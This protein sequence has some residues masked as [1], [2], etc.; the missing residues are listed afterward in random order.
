MLAQPVGVEDLPVETPWGSEEV[1]HGARQVT[2]EPSLDR[3]R[4]RP[5]I[6]SAVLDVLREVRGGK[7]DGA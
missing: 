3:N 2:G 1:F 6:P 7:S 4:E 5:L